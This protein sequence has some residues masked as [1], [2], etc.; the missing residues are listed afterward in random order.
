[1]CERDRVGSTRK[2]EMNPIAIHPVEFYLSFL[3]GAIMSDNIIEEI[4]TDWF[5]QRDSKLGNASFIDPKKYYYPFYAMGA[6][7]SEVVVVGIATAYNIEGWEETNAKR[8]RVGGCEDRTDWWTDDVHQH[9]KEW[10]Q[11]RQESDTNELYSWLVALTS[12]VDINPPD[13][14]YTNLQK[15]GEFAGELAD[16]NTES[17]EVWSEYLEREIEFVDPDL[18]VTLGKPPAKELVGGGGTDD[19]GHVGYE[20]DGIPVLTLNHWNYHKRSGE[21]EEGKAS[22]RDSFAVAYK[23]YCG[24]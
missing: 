10:L 20:F 13:L 4:W 7:D 2:R 5:Y 11:Q 22:Y 15:D 24:N 6:L 21:T 1:M 9:R 12:D 23:K 8:P 19:H 3:N 16:M 18:I 14:Y 17:I